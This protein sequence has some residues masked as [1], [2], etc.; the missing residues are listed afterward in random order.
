MARSAL[1]WTTIDLAKK[2]G[3]GGNTV[4]RFESG[5]DA[6]VSSVEKMR[7]ALE[8]AGLEFIAENGGGSGVRF[9]KGSRPTASSK[10]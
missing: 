9:A 5:L 1:G 10:N 6:R 8:R 7:S 4:N 3:I 2:A